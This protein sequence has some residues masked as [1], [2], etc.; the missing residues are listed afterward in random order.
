VGSAYDPVLESSNICLNIYNVISLYTKALMTV[1]DGDLRNH[2]S[3]W[4]VM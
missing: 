1:E 4:L 3:Y 2:V